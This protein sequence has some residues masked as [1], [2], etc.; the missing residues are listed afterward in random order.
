MNQTILSKTRRMPLVAIFSL[1]LFVT[2]QSGAQTIT[3]NK[4]GTH[5]GFYYSYWN[6]GSENTTYT[7]IPVMTLGA[8]G[9]YSVTWSNVYNFTAGKGWSKGSPDR[10]IDFT[11][12]FD[13]GSN[14]YL[15][16]YGWT[17]NPLIEYYVVESYGG[18]IPP[19]GTSIGTFT[20][21]GGT[22]KIYETTRTNQP[23]IIG[24]ATFQQYWSVRTTRRSSGKVTFANHVAAWKAKGMELGTT[25]DY[26]I[27]ETEGY[28][29]N[30]S[31]NI[32]VSEGTLSAENVMSM[33][34]EFEVYPN[35][36]T[37]MVYLT[38]P[39]SQ[40]EIRLLSVNGAQLMVFKTE[41]SEI[42]I[43]MSKYEAGI[44]LLKVVT[45]G[46]TITKKII[47]QL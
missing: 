29:S 42:E 27:M 16:V 43:D 9:N 22:Y 6:Q 2:F 14:G 25:W 38:L 40:S 36:V 45:E 15:A 26:Q 1:L 47:K 17:K 41:K 39:V 46:Q 8:A 31:S 19:G 23:S 4:T 35:P 37:D 32:T 11:G 33:D 18:W 5:D 13:G 7:G 3:S 20:C 12:S 28:H 44:Y 21:D 10:V 24:T 30:G 34:K